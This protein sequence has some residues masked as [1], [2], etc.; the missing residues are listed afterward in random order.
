M[1]QLL[2][3]YYDAPRKDK[4]SFDKNIDA[5]RTQF[6]FIGENPQYV[7]IKKLY[8]VAF[9][10]NPRLVLIPTE[11]QINAVTLDRVYQMFKERFSDAS[12]QTFVFVGNV[13]DDDVQMISKYLGNLP[14]NGKQKGE[15]WKNR[16]PK[17]APGVIH[18]TVYKG[19]DNQGMLVM[20][21]E[22]KGFE[23]TFENRMII[24]ELS[25]AMEITALE[26]I[27]EKM[28]GTYSPSVR[29]DYEILP[30]GKVT[31]MF[32]IGCD[33]DKADVIEAAAL[34]ILKKY[35]K[36]GPDKKT[37]NKVKEQLIHNRL[38]SKQNNSF[39]MGQIVGSYMYNESRDE[40]V[41]NYDQQVKAVTAKQI[42]D[43]AAK[44]LNFNN[45]TVVTLKPEKK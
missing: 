6:K 5:L 13:S 38:K 42:K 14:C 30:T 26:I 29:A 35:A 18:E 4:E 34:D 22:T 44:V 41:N 11:E 33:P 19:T 9:Q 23:P 20:M 31:W 45:Y 8:E 24:N 17:F 43:M 40:W 39:W 21:G 36:K 15:T 37:L 32:Y 25:D 1:L 16:E 12:A 28:G 7:L 10:N 27:R 2:Y 3:L